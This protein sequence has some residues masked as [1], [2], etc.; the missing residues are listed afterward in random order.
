MPGQRVRIPVPE[1]G[2]DLDAALALPGGV[3]VPTPA[4]VVCHPHPL[5]GGDMDNDVVYAICTALLGRGIA[6]LRFNF[7]GVGGSGGEHGGGYE[8]REDVF[9]ALDWLRMRPEQIDPRRLGLA[10]YSFGAAVALNAAVAAGV[11]A[12]C[13]VSPPPQML[14]FSA[15][16][17]L[18]IP[19]LLIAGDAD[20]VAPAARLEQLPAAIGPGASVRIVRGA[21]HFWYGHAGELRD[22]VGG[23]FAE[24]LAPA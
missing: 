7:R 22:A 19:V 5:Y 11:R 1:A 24:H 9:A 12:L 2:F 23:F 3:P 16:Q 13:A 6:A 18:D 8:E 10:G 17:G 14:D 15:Q 21:D 4:V 20:T